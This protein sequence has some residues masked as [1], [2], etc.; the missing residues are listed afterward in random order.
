MKLQMETQ[1]DTL[2]QENDELEKSAANRDQDIIRRRFKNFFFKWH[3]Q[4]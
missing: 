1:I 4:V 3:I 2:K